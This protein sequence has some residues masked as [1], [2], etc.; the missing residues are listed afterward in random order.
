MINILV[1]AARSP[2]PVPAAVQLVLTTVTTN[3]YPKVVTKG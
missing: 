3:A 2:V 1:S